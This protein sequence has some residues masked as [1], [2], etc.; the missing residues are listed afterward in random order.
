MLT[1]TSGAQP[2]VARAHAPPDS[3][4]AVLETIIE[5]I[6][7]LEAELDSTKQCLEDQPSC[8]T[9]RSVKCSNPKSSPLRSKTPEFSP[10]CPISHNG[11]FR[12]SNHWANLASTEPPIY[13]KLD[14]LNLHPLCSPQPSTLEET[15]V[16]NSQPSDSHIFHIIWG[17][18]KS[19][20][21]ADIHACHSCSIHLV[22][23]SSQ[24]IPLSP[25]L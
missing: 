8:N 17:T 12:Q 24:E 16:R 13:K 23:Y 3:S 5:R 21:K 22:E 18:R 15:L 6:S 2:L 25:R 7:A 11:R 4:G 20:S 9:E 1:R 10:K 19:C 14:N